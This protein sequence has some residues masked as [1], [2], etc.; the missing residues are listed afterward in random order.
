ML[1]AETAKMKKWVKLKLSNGQPAAKPE[2]KSLDSLP[3]EVARSTGQEVESLK[4]RR[5]VSLIAWRFRENESVKKKK[6]SVLRFY[7]KEAVVSNSI[8]ERLRSPHP[9]CVKS[10]G[11][12]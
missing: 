8:I 4:V 10:D 9:T 5:F 3:G 12:K 11:Q 1:I 2:G 7:G 6:F